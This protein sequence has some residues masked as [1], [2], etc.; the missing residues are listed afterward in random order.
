ML[1]GSSSGL[2]RMKD[3]C[4]LRVLAVS[5]LT[6]TVTATFVSVYPSALAEVKGEG[7][8]VLLSQSPESTGEAT[9]QLALTSTLRSVTGHSNP[10][11]EALEQTATAAV[12]VA[13]STKSSGSGWLNPAFKDI[14]N[15]VCKYSVDGG[16]CRNRS[17]GDYPSGLKC[18]PSYCCSKTHMLHGQSGEWCTNKWALCN[19]LLHYG[20]S[21]HGG[22]SCDSYGNKCPESSSCKQEDVA[23]GGTY[24]ECNEGY[25]GDGTSCVEDLCRSSPC[26]PGTC[27]LVDGQ[28]QC[29]CPEYYEVNND[30]VPQTC[31]MRDMCSDS[32]CG[33]NTST[34]ACYHEGPGR[35]SC[36]CNLGY[37]SVKV[38]GK[39][40][41]D[42][43]FNHFVCSSNPCGI[44]GVQECVDTSQG[45]ICTC[46]TGHSLVKE[47]AQYRCA[48]DDPCLTSPCGSLSTANRCVATS[49]AYMCTCTDGYTVAIGET[50][51]Y[52]AKD[53]EGTNYVLYGGIGGGVLL[54]LSAFACTYMRPDSELNDEEVKFLKENAQEVSDSAYSSPARGW[55]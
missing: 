37:T 2:G 53:E 6:I 44:E 49:T 42:D 13:S 16:P 45:V 28:V 29:T 12:E 32:P 51:Q 35:Y 3:F 1:D 8:G 4:G 40:M 38:E 5:L 10:G 24:C 23:H 25:I 48:R 9:G 50:G 43:I 47:T 22:C 31:W 15:Y 36:E 33:D 46:F 52:C 21:S 41:C 19:G 55:G 11:I 39:L 20:D 30:T 34:K 7:E 54:L 18:P 26:H 14:R 17:Y 27:M